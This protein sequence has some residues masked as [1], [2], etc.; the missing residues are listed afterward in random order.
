MKIETRKLIKSYVIGG[1]PT[2]IL[3]GIDLRIE[4]GEFVVLSGKSGAGKST[5]LYQLSLLS[6]PT[7][8]MVLTDGSDM[9]QLSDRKRSEFRLQ[10][11]GFVFQEFALSR[12]LTA[13]ENIMLPLLCQGIGMRTAKGRAHSALVSVEMAHRANNYSEQLSGGEQQRVA[14]GRAIVTEPKVLFAD[15]PTASL[16]SHN[17]QNVLQIIKDLQKSLGI[18]AIM[19]THEEQYKS[20]GDRVIELEDGLLI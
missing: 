10:N 1:K 16:D 20:I 13:L 15:E 14:I 7:A 6:R 3:K 9:D 11:F 2:E 12:D 18:T 5:L 8:G 19:I 17:S 4:S